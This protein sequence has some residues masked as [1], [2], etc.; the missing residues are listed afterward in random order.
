MNPHLR[1]AQSVP[2]RPPVSGSGILDGRIFMVVSDAAGLLADAP[3]W[4]AADDAALRAWFADL[5]AWLRESDQGQREAAARNNHATWYTAQVAAYARYTGQDALARDL[6]AAAGPRL[7]ASHVEPDGRQPHELS[8]TRPFHYSVFNLEAFVLLAVLGD[9]LGLDLWGYTTPAGASPRAALEY[10]LPYATGTEPWPYADL[11]PP[12]GRKLAPLLARA[13]AAYPA[14][15]YADRLEAVFP[16]ATPLQRLY[17]RLGVW[18]TR[19]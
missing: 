6:L 1:Y 16:T 12:D 15:P 9:G 14:G 13:A 2:G 8:R 7:V 19:G 4:T 17:L 11:E 3:A 10:L 18:W 5:L